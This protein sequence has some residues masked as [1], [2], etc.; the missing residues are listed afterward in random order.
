MYIKRQFKLRRK[1][2]Y[3]GVMVSLALSFGLVLCICFYAHRTIAGYGMAGKWPELPLASLTF[4]LGWVS[5]TCLIILVWSAALLNLRHKNSSS[6][7]R[8]N[9]Y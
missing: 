7:L 4:L 5:L 8:L 3:R 1:D 2:E 6:S 9:R